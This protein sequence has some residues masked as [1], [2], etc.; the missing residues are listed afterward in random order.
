MTIRL[1]A[2]VAA[3]SGVWLAASG[4]AAQQTPQPPPS[5]QT[6][7]PIDRP[8]AFEQQS[9]FEAGVWQNS[10]TQQ[11][12]VITSP[13]RLSRA[14]RLAAMINEGKCEEAYQLALDEGDRRVARR[15]SQ[16]CSLDK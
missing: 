3:M 9:Q 10:L 2:A 12:T 8:G 7:T 13:A 11:A 6:R 16:I 15:I 4:T 1:L 14:E 5:S